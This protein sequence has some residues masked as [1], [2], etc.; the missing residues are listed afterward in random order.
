M[1]DHL[2]HEEDAAAPP[3]SAEALCDDR[4][5][6]IWVPE[7][8][9]GVTL[10]DVGSPA[11]VKEICGRQRRLQATFHP[12]KPTGDQLTSGYHG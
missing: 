4:G 3:F 9:I 6:Q 2:P 1:S 8:V 11:F 12:D 10:R 5:D 7:V